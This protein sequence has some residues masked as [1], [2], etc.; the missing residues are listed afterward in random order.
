M[1]FVR[2]QKQRHNIESIVLDASY[3]RFTTKFEL[4]ENDKL[5]Y[6]SYLGLLPI[7]KC[8]LIISGK[9]FTLKIFWLLFWQSKLINSN[10]VVI[11]ELIYQRRKRSIGLLI[12]LAIA[13]M[14][15]ISIVL[16]SKT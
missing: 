10:G 3:D 7:R 15:K 14:A 12:Y 16:L 5:I 6:S 2:V 8:E 11:S 1:G 9:P 13:S 4:K